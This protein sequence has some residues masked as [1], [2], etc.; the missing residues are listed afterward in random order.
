MKS[1]ITN[2]CI[3]YELLLKY[4]K[5]EMIHSVLNVTF[6][7]ILNSIWLKIRINEHKS[8]EF[9]LMK[10]VYQLTNFY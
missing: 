6:E 2:E 5:N 7:E 3:V 1:E 9:V 8:N 10:F 4:C